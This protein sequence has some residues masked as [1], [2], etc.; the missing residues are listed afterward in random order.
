MKES[1]LS[2]AMQ[3]LIDPERSPDVIRIVYNDTET[4]LAKMFDGESKTGV[5]VSKGENTEEEMI[6][7]ERMGVPAYAVDVAASRGLRFDIDVPKFM[8]THVQPTYA[9]C[10]EGEWDSE[11]SEVVTTSNLPQAYVALMKNVG[12]KFSKKMTRRKHKKS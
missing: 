7:I 5:A 1:T 3:P 8:S 9:E 10:V 4:V 2:A 12:F 6:N 11:S